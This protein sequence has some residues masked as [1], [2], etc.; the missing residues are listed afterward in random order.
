LKCALRTELKTTKNEKMHYPTWLIICLLAQ[1]IIWF[2]ATRIFRFI[3]IDKKDYIESLRMLDCENPEKK[4]WLDMFFDFNHPDN[5]YLSKYRYKINREE[6][7]EETARVKSLAG[8]HRL[9]FRSIFSI[10][11][12]VMILSPAVYEFRPIRSDRVQYRVV[13]TEEGNVYE[14]DK[15]GFHPFLQGSKRF[16]SFYSYSPYAKLTWPIQGTSHKI[17]IGYQ[18]FVDEPYKAYEYSDG[19]FIRSYM[20]GEPFEFR[21]WMVSS[22]EDFVAPNQAETGHPD[23]GSNTRQV[24]DYVSQ[25]AKEWSETNPCGCRIQL[26]D[27]DDV[28]DSSLVRVE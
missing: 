5:Y 9:I 6:N 19:K 3:V 14:H 28:Y 21:E 10:G 13:E 12:C 24:Y 2:V 16:A 18:V 11:T 25:K 4:Y 7:K 1:I 17:I 20:I 15:Q 23:F 26:C 8:R 27:F 22:F